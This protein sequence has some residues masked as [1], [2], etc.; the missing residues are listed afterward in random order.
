VPARRRPSLEL[1]QQDGLS[2]PQLREQQRL[3]AH[4]PAAEKAAA[5]RRAALLREQGWGAIRDWLEAPGPHPG[6][7]APV[8]SSR[9]RQLA[10]LFDEAA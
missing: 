6:E 2:W 10:A 9:D 8:P 7:A 3:T 1:E 5:A 4:I